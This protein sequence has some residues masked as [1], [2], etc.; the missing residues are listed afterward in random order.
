MNLLWLCA[1]IIFAVEIIV[2][3]LYYLTKPMPPLSEYVPKFVL[4]PTFT[5]CLLNAA[6]EWLVKRLEHGCKRLQPYVITSVCI[7]ICAILMIVHHYVTVVFVVCAVPVLFSL[8]Y[9]N[10]RILSFAFF[11]S[12]CLSVAVYVTYFGI[13]SPPELV[14]NLGN[15]PANIAIL[16]VA[17]LAG[18]I[19]LCR[20]DEI[21]DSLMETECAVYDA[22]LAKLRTESAVHAKS[23]LVTNMSRTLHAPM[24]GIVSLSKQALGNA[25]AERQK[26]YLHQIKAHAEKLSAIIH[27]VLDVSEIEAGGACL[28]EAAF[29]LH[30]VLRDCET[31]T[32]QNA[33]KKGLRLYFYNETKLSHKIIGDAERLRQVLLVFLSNAVK[34]TDQGSVTLVAKQEPDSAKDGAVKLSFEISDTGLGMT[35]ERRANIFEP[36]HQAGRTGD[37]GLGLCVAKNLIEAMGGSIDVRSIPDIGSRFTFSLKFPLSHEQSEPE[38]RETATALPP[39]FDGDVLLC[40]DDEISRQVTVQNL[41]MLG[42]RVVVAENGQAGIEAACKRKQ[43]GNPF[44]LIFMDIHMPV[45]DGLQAAKALAECNIKAPVIAMTM[46][47]SDEDKAA[48]ISAG[49]SGYLSKPFHPQ[50]LRA[51]LAAHL[52]PDA[53]TPAE[54]PQQPLRHEDGF[55]IDDAAGV[56]N[57][58]GN[59]QAYLQALETFANK[60][61]Q[62]PAALHQAIQ[63]RDFALAQKTAHTEKG[64]AAIIGARKLSELLAVLEESFRRDGLY[65]KDKMMEEYQAEHEKVLRCIADFCA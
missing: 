18:R 44:D 6:C 47:A 53:A 32:A 24:N 56:D 62:T 4:A 58:A 52:T 60:Y 34:F 40:E 33:A 12:L 37:A 5:V 42:L 39:L 11:A 48:Y 51:C 30:R 59:K 49:M 29:D 1:V 55:V 14:T 2:A 19:T 16:F 21:L 64:A 38:V 20:F 46:N 17:Y 41:N 31:V 22:E 54:P 43:E 3:V 13:V 57:F 10:T 8:V 15:L 45:M 36:F 27:D 7:L 28:A 35:E 26:D 50:K 23:R 9:N 65:F 63:D 61:A 25:P